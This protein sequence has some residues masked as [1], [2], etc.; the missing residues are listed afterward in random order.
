V[1]LATLFTV[2]FLFP[3]FLPVT[4]DNMSEYSILKFSQL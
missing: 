2:F 3:P 1:V 4:G